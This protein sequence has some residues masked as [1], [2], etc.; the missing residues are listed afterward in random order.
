MTRYHAKNPL[1]NQL[2]SSDLIIPGQIPADP[3]KMPVKYELRSGIVAGAWCTMEE[4]IHV[5]GLRFIFDFTGA[6]TKHMTRWSLD[7]IRKWTKAWQ[8]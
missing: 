1:I 2:P 7:D 8:V 6:T 5:T 4:S 3:K